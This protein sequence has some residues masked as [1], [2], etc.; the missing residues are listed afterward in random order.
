ME[1]PS[2]SSR[3]CHRCGRISHAF[4]VCTSLFVIA[5]AMCPREPHLES[6]GVAYQ[7]VVQTV[8]QSSTHTSHVFLSTAINVSTDT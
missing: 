1:T 3:T 2:T 6:P 7:P 8:V 5:A 4:H